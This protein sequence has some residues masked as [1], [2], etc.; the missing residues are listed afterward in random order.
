MG[1]TYAL[2]RLL[3]LVFRVVETILNMA[4][5]RQKA[6]NLEAIQAAIDLAKK[7]RTKEEAQ[8]ASQALKES[9]RKR[10]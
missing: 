2:I 8:H 5:E 4:A 9:F 6:G 1:S 7:A 10:S 3:V